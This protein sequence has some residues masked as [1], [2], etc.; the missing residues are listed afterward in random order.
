MLSR[1]GI[2]HPIIQA[3][4]AG[5]STPAMAAAVSN[6]GGL[7]SIGVGAMNHEQTRTAIREIKRL[8]DK[9]FNVNV[10]TNKPPQKDPIR[11]SVW[12]DILRPHFAGA[13]T[14]F[15]G[16]LEVIYKDFD[17]DPEK[18]QAILDEGVRIL[19]F[20][21]GLPSPEIIHRLKRRG[22]ILMA[23]V[24]CLSEA[25]LAEDAGVDI[26]IAQGYEAGGHR[27]IFDLQAE[28]QR[29]STL[30]LTSLLTRSTKLPVVAAGGIMD[31]Q[32]IAAVM[33]LGAEAAQL[34]TAYLLCPESA[35]DDSYRVAIEIITSTR[36][37]TFVSGR[38]ARSLTTK[39]TRMEE[40][41][42]QIRPPDY[43]LTYHAGKALYTSAKAADD[44]GFGAFW[45]GQ[46]VQSCRS[47]P[48]RDVTT[49]LVEELAVAQ[50]CGTSRTQI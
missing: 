42:P 25:K 39:F 32:G 7:G 14:H 27:G 26:L 4:M 47:L 45:A 10:F 21:F 12:I 23:S 37:T 50:R 49:K 19:S 38:P 20:H 34:G 36:M 22:I 35:A 46:G 40:E 1:L 13:N 8:T 44:P 16:P 6:T 29:L 11:E 15:P 3:P 48:A 24:T 41:N 30:V 5:V 18:L 31:G 33:A 9:P 2:L 17:H 28:D 43:P